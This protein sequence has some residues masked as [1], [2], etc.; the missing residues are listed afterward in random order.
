MPHQ[1][2]SRRGTLVQ[3]FLKTMAHPH[4]RADAPLSPATPH[5]LVERQEERWSGMEKV[6]RQHFRRAALNSG[7]LRT[8]RWLSALRGVSNRRGVPIELLRALSW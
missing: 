3:P 5:I 6:E 8:S 1:L 2:S 7:D 4:L